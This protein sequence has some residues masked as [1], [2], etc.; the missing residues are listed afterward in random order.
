[1]ETSRNMKLCGVIFAKFASISEFARHIGWSRQR[2]NKLVNGKKEIDLGEARVFAK[3]LGL[4]LDEV[5][6]I[7]LPE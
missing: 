1:M 2:V 5:C 3:A 6:E 7:F 4:T